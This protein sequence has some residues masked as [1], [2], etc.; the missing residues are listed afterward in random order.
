V[1]LSLIMFESRRISGLF[2]K[3]NSVRNVFWRGATTMVDGGNPSHG[4]QRFFLECFTRYHVVDYIQIRKYS[5]ITHPEPEDRIMN[6]TCIT[7]TVHI[8]FLI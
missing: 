6:S 4:Y 2:I 8:L 3:I 1:R 5:P 7:V